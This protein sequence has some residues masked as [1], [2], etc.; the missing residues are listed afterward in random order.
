MQAE[1]IERISTYP[2]ED[3]HYIVDKAFKVLGRIV[4]ESVKEYNEEEL[5]KKGKDVDTGTTSKEG[6]VGTQSTTGAIA[7]SVVPL[8]GRKPGAVRKGG[9]PPPKKSLKVEKKEKE[10]GRAHV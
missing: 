2:Q 3:Q 8:R 10:I 6:D 9:R 5:D 1:L 4:D 7:Q